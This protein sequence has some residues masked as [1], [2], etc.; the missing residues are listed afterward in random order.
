MKR[1]ILFLSLASPL[2]ILSFPFFT[3]IFLGAS[4]G[5]VTLRLRLIATKRLRQPPRLAAV[6]APLS[7]FLPLILFAVFL[8]FQISRFVRFIREESP[9]RRLDELMQ[10]FQNL[11]FVVDLKEVM[12]AMGAGSF[13]Q[14]SNSIFRK[15]LESLG[16]PLAAFL[17]KLPANLTHGF[18]L[19]L[20]FVVVYR[21]GR[22][23]R[24]NVERANFIPR[25]YVRKFLDSFS[26]YS[27]MAF[28]IFGVTAIIQGLLILIGA[29]VSGVAEPLIVGALAAI[30]S[31]IPYI[32]TI[33]V[34]VAAS[35][36][37]YFSDAGTGNLILFL[38]FA[39]AAGL[40]DN[41]LRPVLLG[42]S[43]RMHPWLAFISVFGGL[44]IWGFSGVVIGPILSGVSLA[45]CKEFIKQDRLKRGILGKAPIP[46][47]SLRSR[48]SP[49]RHL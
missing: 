15:T 18:V 34:T 35:L 40:S 33:P 30:F 32:G 25:V 39:T 8:A 48:L 9:W 16:D 11:P 44:V 10:S 21:G 1:T 37:L 46:R 36:I 31:I 43:V 19:I 5:V 14:F 29:A 22:G 47:S 7:I 3:S 17:E 23:I 20:T 13:S 4:L 45:L 38:C 2:L 42:N 41:F 28:V 49:P 24:V 6:M 26:N 27:Y 12:G